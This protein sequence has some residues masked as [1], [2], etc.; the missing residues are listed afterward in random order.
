VCDDGVGF[1]P[2]AGYPGHLRLRSMRER[3]MK[4]GGTLDIVSAPGC[5]TQVRVNIP[6]PVA[7]AA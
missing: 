2:L 7:L 3:A 1:Y 5:G 6:L 4:A